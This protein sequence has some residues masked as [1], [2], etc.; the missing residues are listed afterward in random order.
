MMTRVKVCG[1]TRVEDAL[2]AADLG[3]FAVGLVF[4]PGS[5]RFID[6]YRARAI[7]AAVPPDVTTVGV[8]VDQ[9]PEYVK[10]VAALVPLGV[11][12]LHGGESIADFASVG[13]R[14][15]RAIGVAEEFDRT[16]LDRVPPAVTVLLDAHDPDRKGGTGRT[17]DWNVAARV[18][19]TRRTILAGGLTPANVRGA[20]EQVQPYAIDVSSG[21]ESS[22]GVKDAAKLR[23]L[24]DALSVRG[25]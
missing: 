13:R 14:L 2:L 16:A 25:T 18:A 10:G 15:I 22:P 9:S 17:I 20:V 5:T 11:V 21:V 3:A 24:F 12:Q 19:Q 23:A 1:I 4:W 6:P 8:F 7:A